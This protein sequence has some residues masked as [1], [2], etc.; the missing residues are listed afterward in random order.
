ML[1]AVPLSGSWNRCPMTLLRWCSG[2]K[3]MSCP[4][5]RRLPSSAIKPPV[6]ALNRV[7]LPAPLE[8]TMVAKSPASI[9]RLTPFSATF[10]LTVPG[11]KVLCRSFSCSI[12][13]LLSLPVGH[14]AAGTGS[15]PTLFKGEVL[16]DGGHG[17]GHCHDDGGNQLHGGGGHV[18]PQRHRH[19]KAVQAASEHHAQNAAQ[20]GALAHQRLADD[21]GSQCNGH[22]AGAHVDITAFLVLCQQPAGQRTQ[23]TG[24]AQTHRDGKGGVDAGSPHHGGVIAGGADG[25]PQPRAQKAQHRRAGD[26]NDNL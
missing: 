22:H 18:E 8:P 20:H 11:L 23:R 24:Y 4:P 2:A 13:M 9:C 16:P 6:M 5:S 17:D 3:V 12:S 21:E 10:S 15:V 7:D 26:G 1:G 19:D 25:K 14:G